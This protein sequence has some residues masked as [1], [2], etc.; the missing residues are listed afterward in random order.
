LIGNTPLIPLQRV[1]PKNERVR[2]FAKAE[3]YNPGGSVKDRPVLWIIRDGERRGLLTRNKTILDATSGNAGIAYAMIAAVKG[4]RVVLCM[5]ANASQERKTLLA[6]L[7]AHVILTD[8]LEGS[9]GAIRKARELYEADP[10]SYFYGD[11]YSNEANWRAHYETTGP[12]IIR[13]TA[14]RV[15]HFVAALGTAGTMMGVGR[16]LKE[17][18]PRVKV[19]EVQPSSPLHGIEGL[20]HMP[21]SIQPPI[22]DPGFAD[23]SL[24]VETEEAQRMTLRLAAEEGLMVGTSSGA[25]VAAALRLAE[26]LREGVIVT[27]LPDGASRYL[28]EPYWRER[29]CPSG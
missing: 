17:Y 21:S 13:Q 8:P 12:E 29:T 5:P 1:R 26:E 14:G 23:I 6:A 10:K 20:K 2:I 4:Y 9:D 19:V 3:W 11:Q 15:T 24:T 16:R 18:N 7:G 27:V 25:N 22:Y 28:S